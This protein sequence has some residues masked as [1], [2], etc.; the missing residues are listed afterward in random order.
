MRHLVIG[1]GE[2]GTA[3]KKVLEEKYDTRIRDM[4]NLEGDF[5]VLHICYPYSD[6]FIET[7]RA[8][9]DQYNP[10]L[11]IIHSTVKPGTTKELGKNYVYSPVRGTHPDLT[12]S[13]QTF[14]KYFGGTDQSLCEAA[15]KLFEDLD[16]PVH[17]SANPTEIEV[18]KILSTT[19]FGWSI[20]FNKAAYAICD[21]YGVSFDIA[22]THESE[23]YNDGYRDMDH[24][25]FQK[26][27]LKYMPGE[28]GGHCVIPNCSFIDSKVTNYIQQQ[29]DLLKKGRDN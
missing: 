24:P 23:T 21:H 4:E 18:L 22:Y 9:Y 29:N 12:E 13:I 20:L 1:A 19:A 14:V 2:I 5:E 25:E 11:V 26:Q 8:Y 28:I 15:A 6:S 10:S 27:V 3:L 16:V 17:V 7:T